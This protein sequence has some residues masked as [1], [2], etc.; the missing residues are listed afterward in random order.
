MREVERARRQEQ[1]EN[2]IYEMSEKLLENDEE[3]RRIL[4][5][6]KEIYNDE[7]RHHYA[8]FFS[9]ILD[10]SKE[11]NEFSLDFLSENIGV[12]REYI[13][14]DY[15]KGIKEFEKIYGVMDKL[16]D[17]INLEIGRLNYYMINDNKIK[18]M[19]KKTA[20]VTTSLND[21]TEELEEASKKA[22]TMQTELIAVLSIFAAIVIT[23][24]GGLSFLGSA[25]TSINGASHYEAVVMIAIICGMVIFNTIFLMM[26]LVSKITERNIYARCKTYD[27]TGCDKE[28]C[29]G[30][31]RIKNRL[32]YVF[33]FNIWGIVGVL[34]DLI[35]WFLDIRGC[36]M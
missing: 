15:I 9:I 10:V 18:D 24:S 36:I 2:C 31:Q 12:L 30:I 16:C 14:S 19:E 34:I 11:E 28:K 20:E 6:L 1:L 27:C 7:F 5:N 4:L 32:P 26:Y 17:H 29:N 25:M 13:E 33:Y 22:S 21:A 3:I 8:G 35:I 23:F